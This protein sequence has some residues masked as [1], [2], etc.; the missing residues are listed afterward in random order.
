M[1]S[2]RK[3]ES[4]KDFVN[5]YMNSAEAKRSFPDA[6]QRAAVAHSTYRNRNK[7]K[8]SKK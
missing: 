6:K 8:R 3:G 7:K 4:E 5:R 1:P 2:P